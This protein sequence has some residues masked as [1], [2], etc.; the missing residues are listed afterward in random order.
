MLGHPCAWTRVFWGGG[1]GQTISQGFGGGGWAGLHPGQGLALVLG[2][3]TPFPDCSV[4]GASW[5]TP[6]PQL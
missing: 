4:S 2:F 5:P 1:V 3:Q 6:G